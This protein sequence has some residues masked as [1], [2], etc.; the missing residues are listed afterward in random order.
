MWAKQ[1]DPTMVR[2]RL[3]AGAPMKSNREHC[4]PAGQP[5]GNPADTSVCGAD[6]RPGRRLR[7]FLP[8]LGLSCGSGVLLYL[9]FPPVDLWP[10]SYV[11]LVPLFV[12]VCGCSSGKRAALCGLAGGLVA[13]LPGLVWLSSVTVGGWIALALYLSAYL[14]ATGLLARYFRGRYPRIWPL[15]IAMAWAGLELVRGRLATGFPYLIYGYTQYRFTALV[16]LTAVIGV[17]GVSFVLVFFNAS[18]AALALVLFERRRAG[19]SAAARPALHML[20]A[21]LL[22][23][24]VCAVLGALWAS[25][26]PLRAGPRVGVVQQNIPRIVSELIPPPEVRH[27]TREVER[28]FREMGAERFWQVCDTLEPYRILEVYHAA[29]YERI[30][31]E[32]EKAARLSRT[33]EGHGIRLLVWPESTVEVPLNVAPDVIPDEGSRRVQ[34]FALRTLAGLGQ[35][36]DCYMLIGAP[37]WYPQSEG[38]VQYVHYGTMVRHFGNSA[39]F[40]TPRGEFAGRYDKMHLVPFGEYV[41]L[42][43]WLPFLQKLTPM[44]RQITPGREAVI[45]ELPLRGGGVVRFGTL[46]CYEDVVPELVREFRRKGAQVLV[47]ITDEGWYRPPGELKQH[48][49]MAVFRAVETRTTLVRAANTGI[50]CFIDPRGVIYALVRKEVDGRTRIRDVEGARSANVFLSDATTPYV[51]F[52]DVFAWACLILA[53]AVPAARMFIPRRPAGRHGRS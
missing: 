46:V 25:R 41:P 33:L 31:R 32:I 44:T 20:A 14:A 4:V 22:L 11:A 48:L 6:S 10:V 45:F 36:M 47:N 7:S 2:V 34:A 40:L 24:C 19:R 26:V 23:I 37:S 13:Y 28:L 49:A 9:A 15:L 39:I 38:Y 52:G 17:Y 42:R 43:E 29:Y 12:A 50:S 30:R 27:A 53:V 1:A 8:W 16:Q 3:S 21:A 5:D 35:S 18:A 51:R